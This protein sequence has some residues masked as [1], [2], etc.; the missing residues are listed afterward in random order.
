MNN[1]EN[2]SDELIFKVLNK[3]ASEAEI[4][5]FREWINQTSQNKKIF[6]QLERLWQKS[7]GIADYYQINQ[8]Q[9]WN[10]ISEKIK[11]KQRIWQ[12]VLKVAAVVAIAYLLGVLTMYLIHPRPQQNGTMIKEISVKVP[13]G[14]KTEVE[15]SDGTKVWLNSGSELHYPSTFD[16]DRRDIF[17]AGEAYFDVEKDKGAPFYVHT[18]EIDIRVLGTRFNVKSYPEESLVE[19]ILEEGSVHM[20]KKGSG[21]GILLNPGEK[22]TLEK[23]PGEREAQFVVTKNIDAEVYTSWKNGKLVF[24]R[25]RFKDL[26]VKL[27]RW[28]NVRILIGNKNLAEERVTGVFENI[29]VEQALDAL[30][31]SVPFTYE[32]N[33][34]DITIK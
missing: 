19:T 9:A 22:A 32:I 27:E 24:K 25:E 26:A 8:K 14:S 30:K 11:P 10:T 28:Y 23:L 7:E 3:E 6:L 17:L 34:N 2:I 12:P 18:N 1:K 4:A 31:I 21:Q 15:L 16:R 13:L 33:K 5:I 20:N 29:S